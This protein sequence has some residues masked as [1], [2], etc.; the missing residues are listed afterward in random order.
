MAILL[1]LLFV[2]PYNTGNGLNLQDSIAAESFCGW[3]GKSCNLVKCALCPLFFCVT[4]INQTLDEKSMHGSEISNWKCFC[5][6]P[7][8]LT[9]FVMDCERALTRFFVAGSDISSESSDP[10]IDHHPRY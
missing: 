7:S 5:C 8:Q 6:S 1:W 2:L 9:V 4:C 3:C 10:D